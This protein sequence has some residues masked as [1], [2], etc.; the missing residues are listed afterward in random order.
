MDHPSIT[1]ASRVGGIRQMLSDAYLAGGW[2]KEHA[3]ISKIANAIYASCYLEKLQGIY[4]I[5]INRLQFFQ[6]TISI[7]H[8][9]IITITKIVG[10][11][12]QY[13][14]SPTI[15]FNTRRYVSNLQKCAQMSNNLLKL[16]FSSFFINLRPPR[17]LAIR[18]LHYRRHLV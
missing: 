11:L 1:Y 16:I 2:V 6:P 17:Q 9:F 7:I 3:Y 10:D 18:I 5:V 12:S 13:D 14:K 15:F 8:S 4:H